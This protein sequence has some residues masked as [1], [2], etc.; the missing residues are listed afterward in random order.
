[1][2]EL[3]LSYVMIQTFSLP[4]VLYA[5]LSLL[6]SLCVYIID[7]LFLY[8]IT[9]YL[10]STFCVY[11]WHRRECCSNERES[12]VNGDAILLQG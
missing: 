4:Y 10:I 9:M 3:E 2:I 7:L 5:V 1:M 11:S 12:K 8:Y 6:C